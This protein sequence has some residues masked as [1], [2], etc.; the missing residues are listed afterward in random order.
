M[1]FNQIPFLS[2]IDASLISIFI[3]DTT[4]CRNKFI[5]EIIIWEKGGVK[6]PI[7]W[8]TCK[9]RVL[10]PKPPPVGPWMVPEAIVGDRE[11]NVLI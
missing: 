2:G 5:Y 4:D 10:L 7:T 6:F 8:T 11:P 3:T 1:Y 9:K